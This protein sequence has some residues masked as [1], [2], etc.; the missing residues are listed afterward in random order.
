[1]LDCFFKK[2]YLYSAVICLFVFSC[3]SGGGGGSSAPV[4]SFTD[5]GEAAWQSLS[6]YN[7]VGMKYRT[8]EYNRANNSKYITKE[9]YEAYA[10][11]Q[12]DFLMFISNVEYDGVNDEYNVS[13]V[14]EEDQKKF[15]SQT[16]NPYITGDKS[17]RVYRDYYVIS[18]YDQINLAQGYALLEQNGKPVAGDGYVVGVFDTGI[19]YNHAAFSGDGKLSRLQKDGKN[20]QDSV[21]L[22]DRDGHGT[23]VSGIIAAGKDGNEM[24][25]V[26]YNATIAALNVYPVSDEQEN[27]IVQVFADNGVGVVNISMGFNGVDYLEKGKYN[28]AIKED[29]TDEY[30]DELFGDGGLKDQCKVAKDNDVLLVMS[31]GNIGF[32]GVDERVVHWSGEEMGGGGQYYLPNL[33]YSHNPE[34]FALLG[35][36]EE[37]QGSILMVGNYDTEYLDGHQSFKCGVAK[38]YCLFAP[39]TNI[40]SSVSSVLGRGYDSFTGS[41]MSA[42]MVSGA[43]AI[44]R[45]AWPHLTNT[46]TADIL[47]KSA[48]DIGEAGVDEVYGHGLLNVAG[49]INRIGN[50]GIA[51]GTRVSND[52]FSATNSRIYSSRAFGDAFDG[53]VSSLLANA[54]YFDD[55]GRDYKANLDKNI[56]TRREQSVLANIMFNDNLSATLPFDS[57]IGQVRFKLSQNS[58]GDI[59]SDEF[60]EKYFTVDKEKFYRDRERNKNLSLSYASNVSDKLKLGFLSNDFIR[61]EDS[62][63]SNQFFLI[64]SDMSSINNIVNSNPVAESRVDQKAFYAS[65]QISDNLSGSFSYRFNG[66]NFDV[67][68]SGLA[69]KMSVGK[70]RYKFAD[71]DMI[72]GYSQL[73]EYQDRSLGGVSLEAFS[74]S[75]DTVTNVATIKL[76]KRITDD[77]FMISGYN[78][79]RTAMSGNDNGVFRGF[80]NVKSNG[81]SVG[82]F[83]ENF[84]GGK[85]AINYS[86][87]L[88]IYDSAV[89]INIPIA[90]DNKGNVQRLVADNVKLEPSGRQRDLELSYGIAGK[91]SNLQFNFLMI[92]DPGHNANAKNEYIYYTK[93]G[94][95]F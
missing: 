4:S 89:N 95:K 59:F 79:G 51:S 34:Y 40:Y 24:H 33:Q 57:G 68:R 35:I 13:E 41:S 62:E 18:A 11:D 9:Q 65:N 44:L 61:S 2:S 64:N 77:I 63:F 1:M 76:K 94:Y 49:A 21:D 48:T 67:N 23:H 3:S 37:L 53:E 10:S 16:N 30:D 17:N 60:S 56:I 20:F 31:A 78:E 14:S 52:G 84:M 19:D 8:S 36:E 58:G 71:F 45:A 7:D 32:Y 88:R 73:T 75:E 83:D 25:G 93:Y 70:L 47:L 15:F 82:V 74:N 86:Q 39:G 29:L 12:E 6:D 27:E 81:Y 50:D 54:I 87:P 55:Y 38:D 42:P 22:Y 28:S 92:Q 80:S 85:L 26:A 66:N 69:S 91:D 46:Q 72:L 43:A 5:N 90:R